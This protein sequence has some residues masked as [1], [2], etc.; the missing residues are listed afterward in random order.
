[1]STIKLIDYDFAEYGS[2]ETRAR[3][4]ARW[5]AEIG[6]LANWTARVRLAAARGPVAPSA[7]GAADRL[8]RIPL[9]L[10]WA[11]S[12]F[13]PG[14]IWPTASGASDGSSPAGC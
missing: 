11:V 5:D 14:P 8:L 4:L 2:S 9:G 1:L 13:C 10:G 3:L 12:P 7:T 6:A